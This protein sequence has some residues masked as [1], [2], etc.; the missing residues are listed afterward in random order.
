MNSLVTIGNYKNTQ[1]SFVNGTRVVTLSGLDFALDFS[2]IKLFANQ[3]QNK[4]YGAKSYWNNNIISQSAPLTTCTAGTN[5]AGGAVTAGAHQWKIT[6]VYST[7]DESLASA[8]SNIITTASTNLIVPLTTIPIGNS[9]VVARNVYRT[10]AGGSIYYYVAQIADNSTNTYSDIIADLTLT[11]ANILEPSV[12]GAYDITLSVGFPVLSTNDILDIEIEI[13][14][15]TDDDDLGIIKILDLGA[16]ELA[17]A[18]SEVSTVSDT[19]LATTTTTYFYEIP[20]GNWRNMMCHTT[21]S[22]SSTGG[23][24]KL[25]RTL[26]PA[27]AVPANGVGSVPSATSWNDCTKEKLGYNEIS[28]F[29][30]I[31]YN[32]YVNLSS[33]PNKSTLDMPDRYLLSWRP[34]HVSNSINI[35]IRKF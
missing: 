32:S 17:P 18:D 31:A 10:L 29:G 30:S 23:Y 34:T 14:N 6:F 35:N 8:A 16:S 22:C 7:G 1:Y 11:T 4:M 20:Q 9:T 28:I 5:T 26:D 3:T 19:N 2:K 25:Y 27:A 21:A 24:I 13:N 33:N 15:S 12:S